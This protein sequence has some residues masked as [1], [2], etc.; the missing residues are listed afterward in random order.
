MLTDEQTR[1]IGHF[2]LGMVASIRADG[3]PAVSPKGTF[4]VLDATRVGYAD[5]RS[6]ATT[7]NL[8]RDSRVEVTFLDPFARK[9]VR[10][11]G[12]ATVH[13]KGTNA[14]DTL[15]GKWQAQWPDLTPRIRALVTIDLT[16]AE[17]ILTPPY[18]DGVTEAEFIAMYKTKYAEIYP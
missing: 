18:D 2:P 14:H 11:A 10:L 3:G 15:I 7:T 13:P 1:L 16:C 17:T 9:A 6:P 8:G 12:T 5:I 4:L